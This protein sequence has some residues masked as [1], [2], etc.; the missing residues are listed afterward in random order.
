MY[1]G[2]GGPT[3]VG[4]GGPYVLTD[5]GSHPMVAILRTRHG[6]LP[7]LLNRLRVH[8]L[9]QERLRVRPGF[10][11]AGEPP[12]EALQLQ[13]VVAEADGL[14]LLLLVLL[15]LQKGARGLVEELLYGWVGGFVG[16]VGWV[17]RVLS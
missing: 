8:R 4:R 1:G 13:I 14:E 7:A 10:L 11:Y 5:N 2:L 9:G 12:Q 17:L 15:Q 6:Q 3:V 16:M